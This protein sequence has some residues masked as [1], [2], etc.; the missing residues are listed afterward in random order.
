MKNP[1][2]SYENAFINLIRLDFG[3]I[4]DFASVWNL[5]YFLAVVL[6]NPSKFE[7]LTIKPH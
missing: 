7:Y 5:I 4:S 6:K 3:F 1:R 2:N